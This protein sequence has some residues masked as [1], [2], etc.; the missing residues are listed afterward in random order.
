MNLSIQ[1]FSEAR[2]SIPEGVFE[3]VKQLLQTPRGTLLL[4]LIATWH[5]YAVPLLFYC[6]PWYSFPQHVQVI[7]AYIN[8]IDVCAFCGI[9]GDV[10]SLRTPTSKRDDAA[11]DSERWAPEVDI[12][13][14]FSLVVK[15]ALSN[16]KS[17][18]GK[19]PITRVD[20]W[21]RTYLFCAWILWY[22]MIKL[23]V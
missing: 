21:L 14:Y 8:I 5:T 9:K 6:D 20:V 17:A 11:V 2:C 10:G 13:F 19:S 22:V 12:E 23:S 15:R 7:T 4:S 16:K 3:T 1:A 18:K